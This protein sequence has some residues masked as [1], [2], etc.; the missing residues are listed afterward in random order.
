MK[1][2]KVERSWI[3]YDV[4]NSAYA[5]IML[6]VIFPIFFTNV[7]KEAGQ[8]GDFWWGVGTAIATA[9]IAVLA[10]VIGAIADIH[11]QKKKLFSG[12]LIMGLIFSLIAVFTDYWQL[13]LIGYIFSHI[14]F[15]ATCLINDSFLTDVTTP[16]KMDLVSSLGYGYGYIGGSTIPFLMS[17]GLIMFGDKIGIDGILAVKLSVI[18]MVIWWGLFSIPFL[19]NVKQI[20]GIEI[21]RRN[22]IKNTF[23]RIAETA[24]K[25]FFNK[26]M[27][28]FIIAY[29]FYI[30][31]VG[32]VISMSTSYGSALGLNSTSMI[33]A[34]LLTQIVAFPCAIL[35]GKLSA[36]FT[37]F[38]MI[39]IAIIIYLGICIL[40]FTMGYGLEENTLTTQGASKIFWSLAFLVGTVQGGIQAI[41]R[42][43][44]GKLVPPKN[45]GEY[46]GFF[47]V[48]GKFAAV[49]GPALYSATFAITKRSSFSILSIILLFAIALTILIIG[50]KH[51]IA[52]EQS[53]IQE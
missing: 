53:A 37:A 8:A 3:M 43:Y 44:F 7:L 52:A 34:L 1:I 22:Y 45:A 27:L 14:G 41:S 24:K 39:L 21:Q 28:F 35:F 26:T 10:P 47:D 9:I 30:D 4:A 25:I 46:F 13:M 40:G 11:G 48:F 49:I 38:K 12:F 23:I 33:L 51:F 5:T 29:F 6:A 36:R 31:G 32:T 16:E 20:H 42:S 2:T 18:I 19:K 50:Q 17:I 15:S